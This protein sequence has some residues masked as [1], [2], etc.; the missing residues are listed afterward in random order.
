MDSPDVSIEEHHHLSR[1]SHRLWYAAVQFYLSRYP[2][3]HCFSSRAL[4]SDQIPRTIEA[5]PLITYTGFWT[6]GSKDN[7]TDFQNYNGSFR[8]TNSTGAQATLIFNG[9]SAF[10]VIL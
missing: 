4:H 3:F 2:A 8:V 9:M 10:V 5:S 1:D 6:E 7:D